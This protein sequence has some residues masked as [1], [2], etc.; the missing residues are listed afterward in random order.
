MGSFSSIVV[1]AVCRF[2]GS[3]PQGERAQERAGDN[4]PQPPQ[5]L[6]AWNRLFGQRLGEFIE[7]MV[8]GRDLSARMSS[9]KFRQKHDAESDDLRSL[10]LIRRIR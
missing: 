1:L 5:Q 2:G 8:H 7:R 9:F 6:A 4:G 10:I 3:Q